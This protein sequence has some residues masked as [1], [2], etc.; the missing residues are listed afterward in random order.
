MGKKR[1]EE[2]ILVAS[3]DTMQHID[4]SFSSGFSSFLKKFC[5]FLFLLF[6]VLLGIIHCEGKDKKNDGERA[7]E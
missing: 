2:K 1:P 3:H 4:G 5:S 7:Q 6:A